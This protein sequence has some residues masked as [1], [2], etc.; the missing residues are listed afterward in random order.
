MDPD[1][2]MESVERTTDLLSAGS[3]VTGSRSRSP[4]PYYSAMPSP[5]PGVGASDPS[6]WSE[7]YRIHDEAFAALSTNLLAL[8]QDM[9][10]ELLRYILVP[11]LILAF[12]TRDDSHERTLCQ[13][14]FTK[15]KAFMAENYPISQSAIGG[16]RLEL[17]VPWEELD[18]FSTI[19]DQQRHNSFGVMEGSFTMGAAEWNWYDMVSHLRIETIC[20]F[21]LLSYFPHISV[22]Q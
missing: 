17:K 12:V 16:E 3:S 14:Y 6:L 15:Y 2:F 13:S 20:K 7:R 5:L 9:D 1:D 8:H 11:I 21:D 10:P 19:S 4:S 18:G 22:S